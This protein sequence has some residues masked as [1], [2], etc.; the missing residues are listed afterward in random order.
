MIAAFVLPGFDHRWGWSDVPV[1]LVLLADAVVLASYLLVFRVQQVN[2]YAAR[3]VQVEQGQRVIDTGPYALVR[4]P[5]YLG[6]LG[7]MLATPLALGSYWAVIPALGMLPVL[8]ARTVAEE[9]LLRHDLPGYSAYT[10][11][12]PHRLL[13]RVW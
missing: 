9:E 7:F 2:A 1:P 12:V 5:M 8:M 4:H 3:I 6:M 13:P 11:R 10:R